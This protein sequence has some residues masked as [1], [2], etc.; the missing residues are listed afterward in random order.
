MKIRGPNLTK[1]GSGIIS[2][3]LVME[4]NKISPSVREFFD[5]F[6]TMSNRYVYSIYANYVPLYWFYQ[7]VY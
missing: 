2:G 6:V 5:S 1:T 3:H 4:R 7:G